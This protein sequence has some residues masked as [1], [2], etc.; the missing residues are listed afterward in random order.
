MSAPGSAAPSSSC[1][2]SRC[3]RRGGRAVPPCALAYAQQV[4][5]S[6]SRVMRWRGQG[7]TS[8]S[9]P[10][11][12]QF[13]HCRRDTPRSRVR[14]AMHERCIQT[15]ECQ[16]A[17][18]AQVSLQNDSGNGSAFRTPRTWSSGMPSSSS[19]CGCSAGGAIMVP[20]V[21]PPPVGSGG[22]PCLSHCR[23]CTVLP[24]GTAKQTPMR[25]S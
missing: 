7:D 13:A 19:A 15:L 11:L 5:H 6:G 9:V 14:V 20:P 17:H 10:T 23:I 22:F 3:H 24:S 16:P 25:A 4:G 21:P 12:P 18:S 2:R 8:A 1:C